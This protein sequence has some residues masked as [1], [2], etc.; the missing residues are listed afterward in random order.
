MGPT[1]QPRHG[2]GVPIWRSTRPSA[3][4]PYTFGSNVDWTIT[5]DNAGPDAATNV[6]LADVLPV[7][8]VYVSTVSSTQGAYNSGTG[9]WTVGTVASGATH[10]IVI[11]TRLNEIGAIT[12]RAEVKANDQWDVDSIPSD[13]GTVP[14]EDDDDTVTIIAGST[15][16]G[17]YVWYDIDGNSLVDIGEPGIANVRLVLESAGLDDTFGTTDDFFGPDGIAGGGDDIIVTQAFT[18]ATGYYGFSNLPTGRFRVVVDTATL[19]GGM[20]ATFN[21][22][23]PNT[24]DPDLDDSSGAITLT[25]SGYL[26]A[27][28]GYTGT[29][30]LGDTVWLDQDASGGATMQLGETGLSGI[31]VTLEWGGPDSDL[32]TAADNVTYPIDTTDGL[33]QYG[34]S[35]LPAGPYRVTLDSADLPAGI[36]ATYDL[37]GTG[38]A[39]VAVAS[40]TAGQNPRRRRLLLR[41]HR[42]D[43]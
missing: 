36:A 18:N 24:S 9:V 26:A 13:Q 29:G 42:L 14:D 17:D 35:L 38:T 41:R 8:L 33:G 12:N 20:T 31:D 15:S 39:G 4:G 2:F 16:L 30:T 43:R 34:F 21:D 10:T 40:L 19:P 37:D 5:L 32:S 6:T 11:R 27:D 23:A 1:T 7:G 25:P 3:P 28:F 22:D